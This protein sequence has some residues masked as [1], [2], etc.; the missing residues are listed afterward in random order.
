MLIHNLPEHLI[1]DCNT[2][3]NNEFCN[4]GRSALAQHFGIRKRNL[5]QDSACVLR[6]LCN[7]WHHLV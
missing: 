2:S 5:H 4:P 7:D 3:L 1:A 6:R